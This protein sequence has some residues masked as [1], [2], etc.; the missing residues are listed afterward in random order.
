MP[1]EQTQKKSL[2]A[3][4]AEACDAVGGIEKKGKNEKQNYKYLKAADVAKAIRR[5]FFSRGVILVFD[6]KEFVQIRTIKTNSG[7]EMGEFMLRSEVTFYDSDSDAKLGPFGAYGVAMDTGDKAIWKAKTG[8]LKYVLRGVGLIPDEKDDP[9]AD[10][11]VDEETGPSRV[12]EAENQF[13]E[14]T[15]AQ[16]APIA[17]V[18]AFEKTWKENGKT[19]QQLVDVLQVRYSARRPSELTKEELQE[20]LKLTFGKEDPVK[21]LQ[22][23]VTVAQERQTA[24]KPSQRPEKSPEGVEYVPMKITKAE[25]AAK[26]KPRWIVEGVDTVGEIWTATCWDKKLGARLGAAIGKA[27]ILGIKTVNKDGKTYYNVETIEEI[28]GE[29]SAYDQGPITDEDIP[30]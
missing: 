11:K 21:T 12:V 24:S 3:K 1:D 5:E 18:N 7:G 15:G 14:R 25:M 10:G 6:E 28:A 20:L 16:R 22:D 27:A 19:D 29:Q 2:V 9:E 17:L 8:A 26:G 4:I 30:F 13:L 23:S